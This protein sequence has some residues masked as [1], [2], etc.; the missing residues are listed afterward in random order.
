MR[1]KKNV[2]I[3]NW[4]GRASSVSEL[5]LY[6]GLREA[7][8]SPVSDLPEAGH[9]GKL[10]LRSGKL[11]TFGMCNIRTYT[12]IPAPCNARTVSRDRGK[13]IKWFTSRRPQ[14]CHHLSLAC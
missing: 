1:N 10:L 3:F 11:R 2:G 12:S 4:N 14:V 7:C 8:H 13:S 5:L 6:G 9:T